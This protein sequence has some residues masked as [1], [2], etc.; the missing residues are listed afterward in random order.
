MVTT[1][2]AIVRQLID[3]SRCFWLS[4]ICYSELLHINEVIRVPWSG[5]ASNET[6]HSEGEISF[7]LFIGFNE[8]RVLRYRFDAAMIDREIRKWGSGDLLIAVGFGAGAAVGLVGAGR[9]TA[10]G[11]GARIPDAAVGLPKPNALHS[12]AT[13]VTFKGVMNNGRWLTVRLALLL[14][15]NRELQRNWHQRISWT[16][17][18][19]RSYL[20]TFPWPVSPRVQS[21]K[22]N[23]IHRH[24]RSK[25]H[26][27]LISLSL[28][29][30]IFAHLID[31]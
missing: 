23:L 17:E 8:T 28:V 19:I 20:E 24:C 14:D 29:Q 10:A 7:E 13:M 21:K 16:I 11:G 5:F 18:R 6:G 4:S 25:G 12:M 9:A 27:N 22:T 15:R 31:M 1:K 3:E 2:I 26:T 30:L